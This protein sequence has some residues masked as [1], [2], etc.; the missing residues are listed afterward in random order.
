M[1]DVR[2]RSVEFS[3]DLNVTLSARDNAPLVLSRLA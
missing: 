1:V 2:H 3:L